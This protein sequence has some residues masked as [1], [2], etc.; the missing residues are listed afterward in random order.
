[1]KKQAQPGKIVF[2]ILFG[3]LFLIGIAI[4]SLA[5]WYKLNFGVSFKELIYTVLSPLKGTGAGTVVQ[6]VGAAL[7]YLI[8]G[9]ALYILLCIP[10]F[11][12]GPSDRFFRDLRTRRKNRFLYRVERENWE[13]NDERR[14]IQ[15]AR[16]RVLRRIGATAILLLLVFSLCFAVVVLGIPEYVSLLRQKTTIYEDHYVSPEEVKIEANGKPKNVIWLYLE[17]METAAASKAEGGLQENSLIPRLTD[18]ARSNLF[19][20]DQTGE[21]VGGFYSPIGTG[22]TIAALLASNSGVPFSFELGEDGNNDMIYHRKFASGLT[23]FGDIL[24]SKGYRQEFLC[25]S[26]VRFAGRDLFYT[27]H[28]NFTIYDLYTART[29]GAVAPDYNDGWWGFE[30]YILYE[31]AKTDILK[32]AESGDPFNFTFLTVDTHH[33]YG[34]T[35]PLC[36]NATGTRMERVISCADRQAAEF[37]EWCSEQDF[38]DDTLIVLI[39]DHPRMDKGL[40]DQKKERR[41]SVYNCFINPAATP[42]RSTEGRICTTLDLFPTVLAAMGFEIEGN[43]LG[44]GVNL[45]SDLPTLAEEYG[46]DW[47]ETEIRKFSSYYLF[48]FS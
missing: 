40:A 31:I 10:L 19:F 7:I 21:N 1:M 44:L 15:Y 41:P 25:G 45:F 14:P 47:L 17:S 13:K 33:S 39:G 11:A 6:I 36:E 28:G 27:Q 4:L 26:D 9:S 24:E 32:L 43:R 34:H 5:V 48:H 42:T 37:V 29:T 3:I 2:A 18:L 35:C 22:W 30:D 12:R 46:Y 38:F 8:V 20:S 16:Q 23:T